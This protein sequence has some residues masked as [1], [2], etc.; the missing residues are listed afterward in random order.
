[1]TV[2]L[3]GS[4]SKDPD[5]LKKFN[6]VERLLVADG[7]KVINPA[8]AM[9]SLPVE[10]TRYVDYMT[11]SLRLLDCAD[12]IYMLSDWTSSYG[13]RIEYLYALSQGKDVYYERK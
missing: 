6:E 1:M 2:Y 11:F 4:I 9:E 3:S 5:Y 13:A 8:R 7:Y 10:H 12:A